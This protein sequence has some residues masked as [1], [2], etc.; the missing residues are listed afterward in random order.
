[1][2]CWSYLML[3][4]KHIPMYWLRLMNNKPTMLT[5][6][7]NKH[8]LQNTHVAGYVRVNVLTHIWIFL[9]V[10]CL[11]KKS[12]RV[13]INNV[14]WWSQNSPEKQR[15][16]LM[17]THI[18]AQTDRIIWKLASWSINFVLIPHPPKTH[19]VEKYLW[20]YHSKKSFYFSY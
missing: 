14:R 19:C 5:I 2:R 8:G 15:D 9:E 3:N 12:D 16:I 6:H 20:I 13:T 17:H 11:S 18:A 4:A 7:W 1:M 10:S